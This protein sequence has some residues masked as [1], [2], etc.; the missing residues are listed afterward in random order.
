MARVAFIRSYERQESGADMQ[1]RIV[2]QESNQR[3]LQ[4]CSLGAWA[5]CLKY[6]TTQWPSFKNSEENAFARR[7]TLRVLDYYANTANISEYTLCACVCVCVRA[8]P[9]SAK[10]LT[11]PGCEAWKHRLCFP[12]TVWSSW[13]ET[14][15]LVW[16]VISVWPSPAWLKNCISEH[17]IHKWWLR[18]GISTLF[19]FHSEQDRSLTLLARETTITLHLLFR[20]PHLSHSHDAY[21]LCK[22]KQTTCYLSIIYTR[23][24]LSGVTGVCWSLFLFSTG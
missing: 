8:R 3:L 15:V 7:C 22:D 5:T 4:V 23:I 6:W 2:G 24:F 19:I 12:T 11:E 1:R 21:G 10:W 17:Y 9:L 20:Y 16:L 18:L 14:I 13:Q